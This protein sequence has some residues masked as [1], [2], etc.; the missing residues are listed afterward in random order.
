[1]T[2][3]TLHSCSRNAQVAFV[4]MSQ[5]EIISFENHNGEQNTDQ[6]MMYRIQNSE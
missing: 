3:P 1:M 5:F 2:I 6:N 4:E